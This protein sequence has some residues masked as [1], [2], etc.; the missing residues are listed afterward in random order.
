MFLSGFNL[1]EAQCVS[2]DCN[3]NTGVYSNDTAADIAYDNMT[4]AFHTTCIKEPNG[5]WKVWGEFAGNDGASHVL[6]PIDFNATNYPA[7]TGT[8]YK[9]T[10][11]SNF[12]LIVQMIVLTSDGL[13]VLGVEGTVLSADLTTSAV[14]Q[15]ITVNGKADGLPAAVGPADVKMMFASNQT[16]MITTCNGSVYVLSTDIAA[17]GDGGIGNELQ[18]SRVM[19]NATTP[20]NNVIV[21]R[22][23]VKVGFAL[24]SDGTLWTW[25]K[26]TNLGNGTASI[27]RPYATQQYLPDGLPGI[28]MIQCTNNFDSTEERFNTVSYYVLGTNKKVYSLGTNNKGQLGD[29]TAVDRLAWVNARN[30]DNSII[31]DAAWISSNEHDGN[32]ASMAVIKTNGIL[33]T[34]GNNS[35]Y[36]VGRTD[37]GVTL[38]GAVNFLDLP[39]GISA[40][41]FI[42]F[43]EVGGH[44]CALIKKC[45]AKYG[46]VGHR[47]RGSIGDGSDVAE[48]I[49]SYDFA[50]PP[51][52]A[53]CGTQ[54]TQPTIVTS[55][56]SICFNQTAIFNI[57][58]V[59]GDVITYNV[60]NGT[61]QTITLGP[62]G[63][64]QVSVVNAIVNQTINLMQVFNPAAA[65]T[66]EL[67]VSATVTIIPQTAVFNQVN[68][69]CEGQPLN[70]LPTT[71]NNGVQGAWFP[72]LNNLQTTTYTFTP[73]V[74]CSSPVSMTI[75]VTPKITPAFTQVAPV[76]EGTSLSN[77][78]LTSN[79]GYNGTWSPALNNTA[80]T[81]YTF[82]PTP[83][84][85]VCLDLAHMT[86][87]V[88]SE[89]TPIFTQVNPI[90]EGSALSALPVI[91]N[92]SIHGTWTPAIN[93]LQTTTYTFTPT[94]TSSACADLVSMTI[95]VN[96]KIPP[97]FPTFAALCY[98]DNL[99]NLPLVS[100]NGIS[101]TWLPPLNTTATT[102]YTF[103]PNSDQCA[104]TALAQIPVDDD[105]DFD[106]G[107]ICSDNNI[108][109][110][111]NP[112]QNN[113]EF[114][115]QINN[116]VVYSGAAFN[117][118]SY[119]E[120]TPIEEVFP[121]AIIIS[122]E[123]DNCYKI[124]NITVTGTPC[125]IPNVITPNGDT[126]NESFDLT[127]YDVAR[128]QIYNR[129]G[130][131]IYD[132][133]NYV[134][135][136]HG[137]NNHGDDLPDGVYFYII[138]TNSGDSQTGWIYVRN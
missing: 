118:S 117:L 79:N 63:T 80:T 53:I 31:T 130:K 96:Q 123:K 17:R 10:I 135:E 66:Y 67:S 104:L 99:F 84:S 49:P 64:Q 59:V 9:I 119:I 93:N 12:G 57:Y 30:P 94:P 75:I 125:E 82:T 1:I 127:G 42:T 13:F 112:F 4:S 23:T 24:K 76:C 108:V 73:L 91:S 25:G 97:I 46:Y 129:W 15:K 18:W 132:K 87:V 28:K 72:A 101:G 29:R 39:T 48:T 128:L 47:I 11:G 107:I 85:G 113:L 115:W 88:S 109:I 69:I 22:G 95:V 21:T 81:T 35:F 126:L 20:L 86:I 98:G 90:C 122:A 74:S 26:K 105:F 3:A 116:A 71:S 138:D 52:I 45:T 32:C 2:L 124:R 137:Q 70:P 58:G 134:N 78:P 60:N 8:I 43:A 103:T 6:S 27:D 19:Q 16:L 51:A 61:S 83:I 110:E 34:C 44:T 55:N 41:D 102:N 33:Y 14:F 65:C 38:E 54:F 50:T 68:S 131:K 5:N 121:I 40:S 111:A 120:A 62:T 89:L 36:M 106:Y 100:N 56:N 37:S 133:A 77:L 92:N 7:L 114:T 136:W